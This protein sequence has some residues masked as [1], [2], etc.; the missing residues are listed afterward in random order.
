MENPCLTFVTPT[1]IAGDKSLSNVI[2]H[3]ISVGTIFLQR[4]HMLILTDSKLAFLEWELGHE[5]KL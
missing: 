4:I 1:L 3:E 5:Q 2:A